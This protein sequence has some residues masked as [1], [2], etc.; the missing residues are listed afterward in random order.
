MYAYLIVHSDLVWF[1][2]PL[3][4]MEVSLHGQLKFFGVEQNA[5]YKKVSNK[6]VSAGSNWPHDVNGYKI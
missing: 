2:N 1:H 3:N 4:L 6:I 5:R